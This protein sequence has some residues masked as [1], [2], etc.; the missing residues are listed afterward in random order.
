MEPCIH[1]INWHFASLFSKAKNTK[2]QYRQ[3][4]Q[5]QPAANMRSLLLGMFVM[6]LLKT[7]CTSKY[8]DYVLY[9]SLRRTRVV[10][11]VEI[12]GNNCCGY[13]GCVVDDLPEKL[14]PEID[15]FHLSPIEIEMIIEALEHCSCRHIHSKYHPSRITCHK[16]MYSR[17]MAAF[18]QVPESMLPSL[19]RD[20]FESVPTQPFGC[21]FP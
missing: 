5:Q 3:Q 15:I 1:I 8:F 7:P 21:N 6:I 11:I 19:P 2:R 12:L 14:R 10:P 20:F 18:L 4:Q 13:E 17:R 9:V 16:Y